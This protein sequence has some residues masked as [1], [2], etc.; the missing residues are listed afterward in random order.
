MHFVLEIWCSLIVIIDNYD[1]FV[2]NIARYFRKLGQASEIIR[3]DTVSIA[4]VVR[5]KPRALVI[6]PGPGKPDLAGVSTAAVRGFSGQSQ[7]LVSASDISVLKALS[8]DVWCVHVALC[9]AGLRILRT[10]CTKPDPTS[11]RA[12]RI[13]SSASSG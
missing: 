10:T 9:M 13:A 5:L 7:F 6:S 4:E 2:F 1:S 11:L 3:N 12:A 8:V